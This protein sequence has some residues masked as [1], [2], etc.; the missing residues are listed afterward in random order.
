MKTLFR[1]LFV[2][3]AVFAGVH[4]AGAV[5]FTLTPAAISNTY[6]GPITL[7]VAGVT[8]GDTVVV[9]KFLDANSNGVVDAPDLLVQQFNLTDGQA[10]MVIGGVTN[11]NVPGDTDGTANGQITATLNFDN[12]DFSQN[13]VG[14]YL[15]KLSSPSG[16]FAPI[17]RSLD[18][19]NFPYA[20]TIAGTVVCNGTNVPGAVVLLTVPRPGHNGPGH[21]AGGVLTDSSG[22]YTMRVPQATY[23]P[24]PFKNNYLVDFS[25]MP[26]LALGSGQTIDTNLTLTGATETISGKAVDAANS[27][28]GLPGVFFH[29]S[30]NALI[31]VAFTDTNGN[32][33]FGVGPGTWNLGGD[34][35]GLTV[36][37]YI[38]YQNGTNVAAGTT[39]V[40]GPFYKAT[41]LFYGTV[42]DGSGNP[43]PGIDISAYDNN[44]TFQAD[45][46]SDAN[47]H[48]VVAALGGLSGDTWQASVASDSAPT[49]YIFSQPDFGQNGWTNLNANQT[50]HANFIALQATNRITGNVN[51]NGTNVVGVQV[52]ANAQI[53]GLSY[54]SQMDTDANG[55]YSLNVANG[56]WTVNIY[57]CGCSDGDS[58]NNVLN[59]QSYQ[60]PP[61]QSVTVANNNPAVNFTV[62]SCNGVQIYTTS[63]PNG[64]NGVYYD[65]SLFASSCSGYVSWSLAPSSGPLPPGLSLTPNPAQ[66]Y[67]TPT[68]SGMF[69]F[70]VQADD[71]NGHSTN[72]DLSIYIA[73]AAP[74]LQITTTSLPNGSQGV[75]YS[76]TLQASGGQTPYTWSLNGNTPFSLTMST[77]GVL[78]G[79]P[80][81][82]GTN[83][84][85]VFVTDHNGTQVFT[86]LTLVVVGQ[87]QI[88][89]VTLPW[90][91][92]TLFYSQ[93]LQASGGTPPYTWKIAGYSVNPPPNLSLSSDGVL[94]G[95]I[96]TNDGTSYPFDVEV[97]DSASAAA[98]QTL[99]L[100]VV[101]PPLVVTNTSLPVGTIG[102]AYSAQLGAT[103]GHPPY[104]WRLYATSVPLPSGLSLDSAGLISGTPTTAGTNYFKVEAYDGWPD[105]TTKVLSIIIYPQPTISSPAVFSGNNF[106]MTVKGPANQN[107]TVQM[108][109]NLASTNWIPLLTTNPASGSF[110]FNDPNATNGQRFYRVSVGP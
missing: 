76:Q 54:E 87:L 70:T 83:T 84:F 44:N 86:N 27:A 105:D 22:H 25:A 13:I 15:F 5:T 41:A 20:Q 24:L 18:V 100:Y 104:S 46:Y 91:T 26:V 42:K 110:L 71:G 40:V 8:S 66:I 75:Y 90:G 78:S 3:L 16:A 35:L 108:S 33:T 89:T 10:G 51:F 65:Q 47:G 81:Y 19:T 9:Q 94:S 4:Q 39:G 99:Y 69:N 106:Q 14:Q 1:S 23:V 72:Q 37:G 28:V 45:G 7:Q 50:V 95:V 34:D 79:T 77:N 49:N 61:G 92:N 43:V 52:Y 74:G 85:T 73:P 30:A 63:L 101:N 36:H 96:E 48:Y 60:D 68:S 55:N 103:G 97:N 2:T 57:D 29:A 64:T 38:G 58:L 21:P 12:G 32:F 17:T 98:Y 31:A 11:I 107:Y 109:S 6:V 59:G 93:Q 53:N 80:S 88:N 67:G 56:D 102:A 82:G 62:Q